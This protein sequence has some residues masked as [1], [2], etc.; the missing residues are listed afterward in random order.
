M[1][2]APPG[3]DPEYAAAADEVGARPPDPP[4]P[5]LVGLCDRN[6]PPMTFLGWAS[7]GIVPP[8]AT[9]ASFGL[10][11]QPLSRCC[12]SCNLLEQLL[13]R[14]QKPHTVKIRSLGPVCELT[15][16][17]RDSRLAGEFHDLFRSRS[18]ALARGLNGLKGAG[19]VRREACE[20]RQRLSRWKALERAGATHHEGE[21][22]MECAVCALA[23]AVVQPPGQLT[24]G[25][26]QQASGRG[27][28]DG[29]DP[30]LQSSEAG[31]AAR[32]E[33]YGGPRNVRAGD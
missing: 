9:I 8:P 17:S 21:Q 24:C 22:G 6:P 7:G 15:K 5:L 11:L 19:A 25:G 33:M 3:T 26:E 13:R 10:L 4:P 20:R 28:G 14:I 31:C 30:G 29:L 23:D 32:E 18:Q 12:S 16:R 27:G 2:L 1:P